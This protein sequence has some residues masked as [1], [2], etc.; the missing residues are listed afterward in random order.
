MAQDAGR[1]GSAQRLGSAGTPSTGTPSALP[2]QG[3]ATGTGCPC[4]WLVVSS[5][6]QLKTSS[7]VESPRN[8]LGGGAGN[9]LI[10]GLRGGL[11]SQEPRFKS[12]FFHFQ[13]G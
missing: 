6:V 10:Q 7:D 8:C 13:V 5:S 9:S 11:W 4:P 12:Q 3:A 2:G 1:R